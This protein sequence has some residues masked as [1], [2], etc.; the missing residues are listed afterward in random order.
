MPCPPPPAGFTYRLADGPDVQV[1]HSASNQCRSESV[2]GVNP[3]NPANLICTSKKFINPQKYQFTISASYSLDGGSTWTESQPPLQAGWDGMTDPDLTFDY[4]GNA[5]LIVEA[6]TFGA[7]VTTIGMFVF[8][9]TDG[10]KTWQ[11]PVQLHLNNADD[12]QWIDSDM[13]PTSPHYG[14]VYAVWGAN[15]P[16]RFARS[17]DQGATWKGIGALPAGSDVSFETCFAPSL[18]IGADGTIHVTWH[19][20][21]STTIVYTRS[22]D[23]GNTFSAV[24]TV[25]N[26]VAS[27]T[28]YLP[29]RGAPGKQFPEFQ[30]GSFRVMTLATSAMAAG[31]RLVVAWA[32][33]REGV[34]RIYY[35][36]GANGGLNW[37]GPA[38]GQAMFPVYGQPDQQHFHPQ[39]TLASDQAVG[40]AFYEFG[41][42]PAK[43]LID[44]KLAF[45]CNDAGSFNDP[46]TVTDQPWDPAVDAPLSH[47]DPQVTFIGEYFGCVG[48]NDWFG[49]VWTD[50]RTMVQELFF[51]R[52]R[53]HTVLIPPRIPQE[54]VTIL[55]GVVQDGGGLVF[56]G[57][58]IIR[59][60]PWDPWVDVLY[61]IAAMDSVK[62][63]R[64]AGAA[65]A[66]AALRGIVAN[67]AREQEQ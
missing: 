36:V 12:K 9:S 50:T 20:P 28:T 43:N 23:G 6:V 38:S 47:G 21:G 15:T 25:V 30:N 40:C 8:K 67:V 64:T 17:T 45:S 42:K 31:N 26:N 18:S 48:A 53:L 54:V 44:V 34:S 41:P 19:Y 5:Y 61:A 29:N 24:Q 66:M 59:I 33:Y 46:V 62:Q 16:L 3:A 27:L 37:T 10:G 52:V 51:D 56:V 32:D 4:H 35:R 60:P 55:A 1:T 65:Q 57:G 11:A 7:D 63:I 22:T 14:A 2:V 58:K 49:I 13:S 39:L